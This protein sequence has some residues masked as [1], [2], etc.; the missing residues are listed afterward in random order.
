MMAWGGPQRKVVGSFLG[1]AMVGL[2]LVFI[3]MFKSVAILAL[4]SI[5]I[6][7]S[8]PIA[9]AC[10]QVIWQRKVAPEVQARVFSFR[11]AISNAMVPVGYLIS[12]RLADSVFEPNLAAGGA[13]ADT[14]GLVYGVG[15]GRGAA[16]MITMFGLISLVVLVLSWLNPNIREIEVRLPEYPVEPEASAAKQL[17]EE[18]DKDVKRDE[19][20]APA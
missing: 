11:N 16:V 10:T 3:P 12:G 7:A 18:S 13:W 14:L 8:V 2:A 5:I 15:V 1:C 17:D 19:G 20:V 9:S 4:G 6:T